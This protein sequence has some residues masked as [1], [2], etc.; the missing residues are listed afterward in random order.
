MTK[1]RRPIV[2]AVFIGLTYLFGGLFGL[3]F[4]AILVLA[5]IIG[6]LEA[7]RLWPGAVG[8]MCLAPLALLA[9]GLPSAPVVG[10]SF[11]TKHMLAHAVVGMSLATAA[12]AGLLELTG[13]A[14]DHPRLR[15]TQDPTP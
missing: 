4:G 3:V 14:V 6:Q 9:Q 1:W 11:G 8:L 5:S 13:G 15:A 7:A 10:P 12:W 2:G